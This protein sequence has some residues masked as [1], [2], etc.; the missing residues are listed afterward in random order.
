MKRR[1]LL[2]T[3]SMLGGCSILPQTSYIQ[4]RDW[5]LVVRR[6]IALPARREGPVLLVR[7]LRAAPGLDQRG[8]QWLQHDGSVHVDFYEQWAVPPS[9]AIEDDLRRWLA[10]AGR[11]SAVVAPGS[12]LNADFALEGELQTFIADMNANVARVALAIVLLDQR[13]APL[14]VLLQK[15]E[16]AEAPLAGTGPP[17][18]VAA[19]KVALGETLGRIEAGVGAAAVGGRPRRK[20]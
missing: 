10:D 2:L 3:G 13:P 19:M 7:S 1:A 4:R 6:K 11:F 5:P 17:A 8:L 15:T 16:S 18:I 20:L 14:K 9:Q 12:R